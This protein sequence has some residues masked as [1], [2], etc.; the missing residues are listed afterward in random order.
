MLS[1]AQLFYLRWLIAQRDYPHI[2]MRHERPFCPEG[3]RV[4]IEREF[5]RRG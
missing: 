4:Q 2:D 3:E 5:A 1:D